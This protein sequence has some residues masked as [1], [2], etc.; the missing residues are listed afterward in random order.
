VTTASPDGMN[1]YHVDRST[2]RDDRY[3]C[4]TMSRSIIDRIVRRLEQEIPTGSSQFVSWR[5]QTRVSSSTFDGLLHELNDLP[6]DEDPRFTRK[7]VITRSAPN[8]CAEVDMGSEVLVHVE[9]SMAAQVGGLADILGKTIGQAGG[10][11]SPLRFVGRRVAA[12]GGALYA[13]IVSLG[14]TLH[15]LPDGPRNWLLLLTGLASF[16]GISYLAGGRRARRARTTIQL[17]GETVKQ[18]WSRSEVISLSLGVASLLL[19][20]AGL[21]LAQIDQSTARS[22][23]VHTIS[24]RP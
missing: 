18:P 10:R 11:S 17:T 4:A 13:A 20:L 7:F 21:V 2:V 8:V 5:E 16:T 15:L 12:A 6:R 19:S 1:G 14:L 23:P 22:A 24:D 9:G 3:Y